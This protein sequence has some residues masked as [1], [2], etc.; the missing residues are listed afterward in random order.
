MNGRTRMPGRGRTATGVGA[1][2]VLAAATSFGVVSTPGV[3]WADPSKLAGEGGSFELPLV[4]AL[5]D[6]T[7]GGAAIAPL[8]PGFFNANVDVARDDFTTGIAD[9]TVSEFPLTGSQAATAEKN[10]RSFAYVPFAASPVA[11]AA[12][13]ECDPTQTFTPQTLCPNLQL[14]VPQLSTIFSNGASS[15]NDP[16]FSHAS[17]GGPIVGASDRG[18]AA[19]IYPENQVDPSAVNFALQTLFETDPTDNGAAKQTW[20]AYVANFSG[21]SDAPNELWPTGGGI[22]G[23]DAGVAQVLIPLNQV[24]LIPDPN[25][26]DWGA[27]D[28]AGLPGDWLGSP[29]N[30]P[31]VAVQNAAGQFASPTSAAMTSALAD[32]TMDPSTNLVTFH[33]NSSN[34]TAYPIPTMSYLIVPTTGLSQAKATALASFIRYVLGPAGQAIIESHNA[35]PPTAAMITAGLHVADVVAAEAAT[36][37]TT[38][39]TTTTTTAAKKTTTTTAAAKVTK[40]STAAGA[41]QAGS[42]SSGSGTSLATAAGPSLAFTGAPPWWLPV[43]GGALLLLAEPSRRIARRRLRARRSLP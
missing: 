5:Q 39:S 4:N 18:G 24:T 37:S 2:A 40:A 33:S 23:G 38:T 26:E 29:R 43:I 19:I 42:G 6:S 12:V 36:P 25:P 20:D 41:G 7:A 11:I 1:L 31:S 14:T 16:L 32:A 21:K 35:A 13:V 8:Q 17:G 22:S 28:I 15:W 34:M 30:I 9:Y 3:S 10:G 27:G